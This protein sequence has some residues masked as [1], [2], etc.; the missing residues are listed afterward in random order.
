D[1]GL[2]STYRWPNL[3]LDLFQKSIN[4]ARLER[5]RKDSS[6]R[7]TGTQ[8]T[9]VEPS[10]P[11]HPRR[12]PAP[13]GRPPERLKRTSHENLTN[14]TSPLF[15][16][17]DGRSRTRSG[18]RLGRRNKDQRRQSWARSRHVAAFGRQQGRKGHQGRSQEGRRRTLRKTRRQPRWGNHRSRSK[19]VSGIDAR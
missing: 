4:I 5:F 12:P 7:A 15:W 2:Q 9:C 17:L 8:A 13:T 18:S 14:S 6:N 1:R 16:Q 3:S 11:G 19:G 10:E